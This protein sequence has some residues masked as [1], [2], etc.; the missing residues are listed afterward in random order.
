MGSSLASGR[1]KQVTDFGTTQ[2]L[3]TKAEAQRAASS[4]TGDQQLNRGCNLWSIGEA[5]LAR[6]DSRTPIHSGAPVDHKKEIERMHPE[7]VH[8]LVQDAHAGKF[9]PE[10]QKTAQQAMQSAPAGAFVAGKEVPENRQS[11]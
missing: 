6:G 5:L 9:G 4:F 1:A 10:A 8:R 7:Q 3:R 11:R 2:Q